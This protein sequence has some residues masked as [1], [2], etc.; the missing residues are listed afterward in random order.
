MTTGRRQSS[1]LALAAHVIALAGGFL[2][3]L[4][5]NRDQW[6]FGD[7]WDF[8]AHRGV[9]GGDYSIWAPHTEHWS[10]GPILI[11]RALYSV[12]GLHTYVPYVVVLLLFHLAVTHFL[13]RLLRQAGV[14]V[15]LA[16]AL[17]A[18]YV[19][20]GSGHENLLWAFQIG[21]IGSVALGMAALLLVNHGGRWGLRD[22]GAWLVSIAGLMFSGVSVTMVTVAGLTVLMRRGWRQAALTVSLP[23]VVYLVWFFQIGNQNLDDTE[24]TLED[25]FGYPEFI[26][27]GLRFSIEQTVGFPGAGAIIVLGLTAYLL[28]RAGHA[29]GPAA[30]AFA[31]AIGALMMFAIIA[32]G[33][34]ELGIEQSEASR[35]TYIAIALALPGIG[36]ALSE[37]AG[38][39]LSGS[40]SGMTS[41]SR[42]WSGMTGLSD[43]WSGM[44]GLSDSSSGMAGL[45]G[46]R[47]RMAGPSG[48]SEPALALAGALGGRSGPRGSPAPHTPAGGALAPQKGSPGRATPG[49][50]AVVCLVLLL[51]G[52]HNGGVLME[53]SRAEKRLEQRL[54]AKILAAAQL[55]SSPEVILG[56]NPEPVY[57][58]D[59]VIDDLRKMVRDDKLPAPTRITDDDRMEVATVLQYAVG[60]NQLSTPFTEPLVDGVVGA[61]DQSDGPGCIRLFPAGPVVELHLASGSPMSL[62]VTTQV[63]GELTGYL[64]IFT[65]VLRTGSPHVDKVAAGVAV[66]V[67][68]TAIVDQV[69]LRVPAAGTTQVCGVL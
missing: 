19:L 39:S 5:C 22:A 27:N 7:E 57:S 8:L 44:T 49:R 2:V 10:T 37:L 56:G 24:R 42:S 48:A 29:S 55:V 53:A 34:S 3:L 68:V 66:Y 54:K 28:R 61:I 18:V 6:F 58:P 11:Y 30:P 21:F 67:N 45:G 23:G 32:T 13:W 25:V 41:L 15:P 64:R 4:Y 46:S 36:L 31:C 65:P 35:Y 1:R 63:V 50:R 14:D 20:L 9:A 16:T 52:L 12:Y 38:Q 40:W 60:P 26:W 62:R 43:S 33:R 17:S 51:V 69:V 59:I 47:T